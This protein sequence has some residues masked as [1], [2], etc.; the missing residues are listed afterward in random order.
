MKVPSELPN[1]DGY[2]TVTLT[3][4][5]TIK[6]AATPKKSCNVQCYFTSSVK[7][8]LP[9]NNQMQHDTSTVNT[10]STAR[11]SPI[12]TP[13]SSNT[14]VFASSNLSDKPIKQETDSK[15]LVTP[16]KSIN[17]SQSSLNHSS[18]TK[19][20]SKLLVLTPA[21]PNR[22]SSPSSQYGTPEKK[23]RL[24]SPTLENAV[25]SPAVSQHK[26][27]KTPVMPVGSLRRFVHVASREPAPTTN[28]KTNLF[29]RDIVDIDG[30]KPLVGSF[31]ST[32]S[33][34]S[35][36]AIPTGDLVTSQSTVVPTGDLVTSQSTT[37]AVP[38]GDLVTSQSTAVAVSTGDIVTSQS[39][40]VAVSTGDLVT[41]QSTTVAV[42]TGDIVTSQSTAVAAPTGD[43]VTSQ[44]TTVTTGKISSEY[45][46]N[47]PQSENPMQSSLI[48]P[49]DGPKAT[50][51]NRLL[52]TKSC[53]GLLERMTARLSLDE[54][55]QL[56]KRGRQIPVIN[57]VS[58]SNDDYNNRKGKFL[59]ISI[60]Y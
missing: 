57:A 25:T 16:Q 13:A 28:F 29:P 21:K 27:K 37:V 19:R 4:Q 10:L 60:C 39:T 46:K 59:L 36:V 20:Y 23:P 30:I 6:G 52:E 48:D 49:R 14:D 2:T 3:G 18:S 47:L 44:S 41:S 50:H 34:S 17:G 9:T 7:R 24:H 26:S 15:K 42:S 43:L 31:T 1:S 22:S 53:F 11:V 32:L 55:E 12:P 51:A 5:S 56:Y 38:T 54:R 58:M 33:Q 8:V 35:A 45:E 40:A